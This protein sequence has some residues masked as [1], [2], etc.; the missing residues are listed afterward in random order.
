MFS[1]E[2][3]IV[4][5][6]VYVFLGGGIA[7]IAFSNFTQ[8]YIN[9]YTKSVIQ[10]PVGAPISFTLSQYGILAVYFLI[11]FITPIL[12]SLVLTQ[13]HPDKRIVPPLFMQA[14]SFV[15]NLV[16]LISLKIVAPSQYIGTIE[17][18][19]GGLYFVGI[20]Y[21]IIGGIIQDSIV[22]WILGLTINGD[23]ILRASLV[24]STDYSFAR[25]IVTQK[26]YW[27]RIGLRMRL[28]K[29]KETVIIR[30]ARNAR[31]ITS[32][33][34]APHTKSAP[35]EPVKTLIN[36]IKFKKGSYYIKKDEEL[37]ESLRIAVL[38]IKD[39]FERQTPS[40]K[41]TES[42]PDNAAALV[43]SSIAEMQ[44]LTFQLQQT[45]TLGWVKSLAFAAATLIAS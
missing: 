11:V 2:Y 35:D 16:P 1:E 26:K 3:E 37:S 27:N 4:R 22:T 14:I 25:S 6:V 9:L 41:A 12:T 44:G 34:I 32:L 17:Q 36:I 21:V 13:L 23:N 42:S 28:Y 39:L 38:Y 19:I 30:S 45:S 29:D 10:L 40:I 18:G 43:N 24:A 33:E 5:W 8:F 31:T 7:Y 15:L 20:Y